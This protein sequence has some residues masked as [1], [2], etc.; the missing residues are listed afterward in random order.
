MVTAVYKQSFGCIIA[1]ATFDSQHSPQVSLLRGFRDHYVYSSFAGYSFMRV[2]NAW[3]YSFSP[4]VALQIT[5]HEWVKPLFK[6]GL[7]PLLLI[8]QGAAYIYPLIDGNGELAVVISGITASSLIGLVYLAPIN[9]LALYYLEKRRES[10]LKFTS[11]YLKS[12]VVIGVLS[13]VGI[14]ISELWYMPPLMMLSTTTL[15][16]VALFLTGFTP[17]Y[18]MRVK[19]RDCQVYMKR[20]V[21]KFFER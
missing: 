13:L 7:A 17:Y 21:K 2:F 18:L 10:L 8:L 4:T 6:V 5:R 11:L 12:L 3:Y 9:T 20:L 14:F 15:V 1:T 16:L 19:K